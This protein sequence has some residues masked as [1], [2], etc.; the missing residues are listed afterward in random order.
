MKVCNT[1]VFFTGKDGK[2]ILVKTSEDLD[3]KT[4][5]REVCS[6]N[7]FNDVRTC[8]DWDTGDFHKDMKDRNGKWTKVD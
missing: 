8:L 6:F 7:A 1:G 5:R 4:L 3:G 2:D